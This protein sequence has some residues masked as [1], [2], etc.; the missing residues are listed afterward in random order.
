MHGTSIPTAQSGLPI[1]FIN[2]DRSPDRL[3]FMERQ[4][5][6]FGIQAKRICGIDGKQDAIPT[7]LATQFPIESKMTV[8]EIGCYASHLV[9]LSRFI[10]EG[11][12][13]AVILEDD[14]TLRNDFIEVARQALA[15]APAGWEILHLSTA[16]KH[17]VQIA[18]KFGTGSIVRYSRL[19]VGTAAYAVNRAGAAKLL[20]ARPRVRPYDMEF[21]YAWL[22]GLDICGVYPPPATQESTFPTTVEARRDEYTKGHWSPGLSS[23]IYGTFYRARA[24]GWRGTLRCWSSKIG[25]SLRKRAGRIGTKVPSAR[26]AA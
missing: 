13:V 20:A 24:L 21:R 26:S 18:R 3:A 14:V 6:W 5:S 16:F 17:P 2:L 22:I 25:A 7:H 1:Y 19:P 4:F 8:G 15:A 10:S 9:A 12:D 11:H 23:Q